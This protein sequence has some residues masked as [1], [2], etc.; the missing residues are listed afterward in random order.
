MEKQ[1]LILT[2][3][4]LKKYLK[5]SVQVCKN[6]KKLNIYKKVYQSLT[7]SGSNL[8]FLVE[9]FLLLNG[10]IFKVSVYFLYH[11]RF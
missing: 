11:F 2:M 3:F 5:Y 1:F 7:E 6:P 9:Q 10:N 4:F 8:K